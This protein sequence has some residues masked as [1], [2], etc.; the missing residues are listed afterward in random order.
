[1]F[2]APGLV[3]AAHPQ[4]I[5]AQSAS[6]SVAG[7]AAAALGSD[8]PALAGA[9][10]RDRPV[11]QGVLFEVALGAAVASVVVVASGVGADVVASGSEVVARALGSAVGSS[12]AA[13]VAF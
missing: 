7:L 6:G 10:L 12:V 8:E 2:V 4:Q 9:A 11:R 1:M 5:G 3:M 13:V